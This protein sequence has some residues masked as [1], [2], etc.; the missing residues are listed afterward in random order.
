MTSTSSDDPPL[1]VSAQLRQV[2]LFDQLDEAEMT[3]ISRAAREKSYPKSNVI[4]FEDDPGDA[5]YVVLS[6]QV[7]VVLIG[8]DGRE[9]ILSML[10]AGDFFGEMSLMS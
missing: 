9:V 3:R 6:G 8:E 5:L 7:K 10:K 1:S 4:L 2:P